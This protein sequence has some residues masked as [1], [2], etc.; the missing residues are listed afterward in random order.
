[1]KRHKQQKEIS[2][3]YEEAGNVLMN[4]KNRK[5]PGSDDTLLNFLALLE[6]FRPISNEGNQLKLQDQTIFFYATR[7]SHNPLSK[8]RKFQRICKKKIG[9][10]LPYSMWSTK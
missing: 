1:M 9:D 2:H 10:Q 3:N 8:I 6:R 5:S 4:L 7:R